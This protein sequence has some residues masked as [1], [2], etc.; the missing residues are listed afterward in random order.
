MKIILT[1]EEFKAL[2]WD[3][4]DAEIKI[5]NEYFGRR[6]TKRQAIYY[7]RGKIIDGTGIL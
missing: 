3:K 1:T 7:F 6:F 5:E 2:N 4:N